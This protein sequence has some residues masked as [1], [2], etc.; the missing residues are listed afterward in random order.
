GNAYKILPLLGILLMNRPNMWV[1]DSILEG[2]RW[3]QKESGEM[4][5]VLE[6]LSSKKKQWKD[7]R[8]YKLFFSDDIFETND[9]YVAYD[10]DI[11]EL[12]KI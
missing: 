4:S 2:D 5:L 11:E 8:K 12:R 3:D 1:I 7:Y 9:T 10:K 6:V